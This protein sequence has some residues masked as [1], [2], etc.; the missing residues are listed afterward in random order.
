MSFSF[1]TRIAIILLPL[2]LWLGAPAWGE[3]ADEDLQSLNFV[4]GEEQTVT[5]TRNTRPASK[6]AENVTVIT[7]RQI[8]ELNA[9]TVSEVLNTVTGIQFDRAGRTPGM[10]DSFSIQGATSSHILVLIDGVAQNS[11]AF[12]LADLGI[13]PVQ[14]IERIEIVKGG[15]S[16]AWGQA[17]GGVINI[18]SK[19][20]EPGKP[21]SG[22]TFSSIGDRFT[23]DQRAEVSGTL[24]RFGYYLSGGFIHSDGLLGNNGIN[25]NNVFSKL[26]YD[27]PTKGSLTLTV[28]NINSHRGLEEV[29]P[30]DDWHDNMDVKKFTSTLLFAYPLAQRLNLELLT[31]YAYQKEE[32]R[33]GFMTMPDLF[34]HMFLK[35]TVWGSKGKLVWGDRRFNLTSGLEYERDQVENSQIIAPESHFDKKFS[36]YG[37][38]TNGT[39][40]FG[41]VTVLPGI[42]YDRVDSDHNEVS[43]TFGT[44]WRLTDKTVLRAYFARGYSRGIALE[45][46]AAPQKGWT[47]QTGIETSDIPYVW[48]KGTLFYNDTWN[49]DT[50]FSTG[51]T[52][53]SQIRQGFEIEGRT[54]PLYGFSVGAGYTL[55]D[56]RDKE[57]RVRAEQIPGDLLKLAVTYDDPLWGL[58]G[59]LTGNYVWWNSPPGYKAEDRTF[60]WSLH[61]TQKL[62]P[63]RELSPELF[64]TVYNLFNSAQYGD[65]HYANAGRWLEGGVR[66]K[67]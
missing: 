34:Q 45:D 9:H 15:A 20:P 2:L 28:S 36:R 31:H 38:Y 42:R 32:T 53:P 29:P 62:F 1:S 25:L 6:I 35:D 51:L 4:A 43:F 22:T 26:V 30:P 10:W 13:L 40:T 11:G 17:L 7:A 59:I 41:A 49:M 19:S 12:N 65:Y 23:T 61:L 58:H 55:T 56:L 8:E 44:T 3:D 48:F 18:V 66:F 52:S 39:L 5:A 50:V 60:L 47:V 24:D 14:Q 63:T 64:L 21:F 37:I 33:W 46:N 57:T 67:F 54:V 27:L 16:A